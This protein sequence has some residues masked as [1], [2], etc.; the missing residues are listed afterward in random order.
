[1][2]DKLLGLLQGAAAANPFQGFLGALWTVWAKDAGRAVLFAR[3]Y[4]KNLPADLARQAANVQ[5]QMQTA[6][7]SNQIEQQ[8]NAQLGA[9]GIFG[10]SPGYVASGLNPDH[11]LF[12]VVM[13]TVQAHEGNPPPSPDVVGLA[14]AVLQG[15][16][17]PMDALVAAVP[18][19]ARQQVSIAIQALRV[20][21][22]DHFLRLQGV[23]GAALSLPRERIPIVV[24]HIAQAENLPP[25]T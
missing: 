9:M 21:G 6:H 20:T 10:S 14:E 22:M 25:A 2:L 19:F 23:I 8:I 24:P 18:V 4:W 16:R 5:Q 15:Q 12:I 1:M 17:D 11:A 7:V 3:W 13:G